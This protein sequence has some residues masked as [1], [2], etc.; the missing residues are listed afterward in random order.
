MRRGGF[1]WEDSG[2]LVTGHWWL[3]AGVDG[4]VTCVTVV[5]FVTGG[6]GR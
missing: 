6:G 3:V 5:T 1:C 4:G 2:I